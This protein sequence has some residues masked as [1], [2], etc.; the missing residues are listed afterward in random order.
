MWRLPIEF[1]EFFEYAKN[2]EFTQKPD[3]SYLNGLFLKAADKNG[4]D[5]DKVKYDWEIKKEE[6]E[7]KKE[8]EKEEKEKED[9]KEVEK[10]EEKETEGKI[11]D[12][13]EE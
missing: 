4:I 7:K 13:R 3:Y 6:E 1:K 10:K 11:G 12:K 8:K 2:L 9:K 5:I